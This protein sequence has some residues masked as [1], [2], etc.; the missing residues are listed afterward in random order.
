MTHEH[1]S[2][3]AGHALASSVRVAA[4]HD[5][6]VCNTNERTY[7]VV[8]ATRLRANKSVTSLYCAGARSIP[9]ERRVFIRVAPPLSPLRHTTLAQYDIRVHARSTRFTILYTYSLH[10]INPRPWTSSLSPPQSDIRQRW[11]R[12]PTC[13]SCAN[14]NSSN[15]CA[16]PQPRG[17]RRART[18]AA[19]AALAALSTGDCSRPTACAPITF[20]AFLNGKPTCRSTRLVY[21][22]A[23][24]IYARAHK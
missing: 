4:A 23:I 20:T 16:R 18:G 7:A 10:Y 6:V 24:T 3:G 14:S 11:A 17:C 8:I 15:R 9:C 1:S 13:T 21:T 19:E 12:C 5:F 2:N 22:I